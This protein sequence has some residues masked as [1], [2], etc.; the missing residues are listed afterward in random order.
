[1]SLESDNAEI[2]LMSAIIE[3]GAAVEYLAEGI[4]RLNS[5]E[6]HIVRHDHVEEDLKDAEN[7]LKA[8]NGN[9]QAYKNFKNNWRE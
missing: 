6:P 4:H 8:A 3:M 5:R 1:M 9:I 7:H 2:L